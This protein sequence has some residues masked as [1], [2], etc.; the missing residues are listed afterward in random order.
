MD[1]VIADRGAFGRGADA[2]G[3]RMVPT[4]GYNAKVKELEIRK[5]NSWEEIA[6]WHW[7]MQK[8]VGNKWLYLMTEFYVIIGGDK[9]ESLTFSSDGHAF[10][11]QKQEPKCEWRIETYIKMQ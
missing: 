7:T 9:T 2:I 1:G 6:T 8:C 5:I 4:A 11:C 3:K 10:L